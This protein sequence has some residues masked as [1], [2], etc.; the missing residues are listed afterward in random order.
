M[1]NRNIDK[2][3]QGSSDRLEVDVV[4]HND[5]EDAFESQFYLH[6]PKMLN[7]I[8]TDRSTSSSSSS[9]L[10][11]PPDYEDDDHR[12]LIC[13][14][15]NPLAARQSVSLRVY[16]QPNP[17]VNQLMRSIFFNMDTNSTNKEIDGKDDDNHKTIDLPLV[18]QT[19][20]ALGG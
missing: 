20:L 6:L 5:G 7:F 11:S 10:C 8:N 3:I 4:I 17:N 9:V 1:C 18:V 19:N 16:L 15:G 13:D 2:V 14:I 12:V